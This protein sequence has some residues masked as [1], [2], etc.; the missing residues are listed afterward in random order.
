MDM[1]TCLTVVS[2]I[3]VLGAMICYLETR[4]FREQETIRKM[5]ELM[6]EMEEHMKKDG[7]LEDKGDKGSK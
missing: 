2:S 7:L 3:I 1:W 6:D 4:R 5:N